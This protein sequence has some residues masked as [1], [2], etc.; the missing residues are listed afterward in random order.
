MAA[1]PGYLFALK[2]APQA[3]FILTIHHKNVK[4]IKMAKYSVFPP[5][6]YAFPVG[7]RKRYGF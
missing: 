4:I 5:R 2:A 7:E 6:I 3:S 1:A